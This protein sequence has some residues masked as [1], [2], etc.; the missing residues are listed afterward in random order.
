MRDSHTCGTIATA[1]GSRI[2]CLY[3]E[4]WDF[5]ERRR[6]RKVCSRECC[7]YCCINYLRVFTVLR[8]MHKSFRSVYPW[9]TATLKQQK[10]EITFMNISGVSGDGAEGL[11]PSPIS[12][13]S[14]KMLSV[15]CKHITLERNNDLLKF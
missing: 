6:R 8:R 13:K 3:H 7:N 12:M 11:Q 4:L 10:I 1:H 5:C 2:Y 14:L 15:F 9:N